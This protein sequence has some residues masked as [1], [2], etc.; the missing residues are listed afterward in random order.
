MA[1]VDQSEILSQIKVQAMTV[2]MFTS[3]EPQFD[4]P[5]PSQTSDLD[6][7]SIVQLV[8]ALEDV[9]NVSLLEDMSEFTGSS[10]EDLAGFVAE[11]I[12]EQKGAP[13]RA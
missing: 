9:Y 1:A 6:S 11:R 3:N 5:E 4:L 7:F 10:F 8:L 2:L 12:R 13:D